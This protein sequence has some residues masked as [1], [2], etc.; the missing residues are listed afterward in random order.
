[1]TILLLT[2]LSTAVLQSSPPKLLIDKASFQTNDASRSFRMG[3]VTSHG[4]V[5]VASPTGFEGVGKGTLVRSAGYPRLYV[6]DLNKND[7]TLCLT[8]QSADGTYTAVGKVA[9]TIE[10]ARASS[11]EIILPSVTKRLIGSP[12]FLIGVAIRASSKGS[13][14][15]EQDPLIPASWGRPASPNS[16]AY[17]LVSGAGLSGHP[18][19]RTQEA[20]SSQACVDLTSIPG[21]DGRFASYRFA[22]RL[23]PAIGLQCKEPARVYARWVSPTGDRTDIFSS[24]IRGLCSR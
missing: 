10:A 17:A 18:E 8:I 20:L 15:D 24:P 1:M 23:T 14:C 13:G 9:V 6:S 7:R 11:A 2:I 12:T 4:L 21:S 19:V 16:G 5:D 22:C 3:E